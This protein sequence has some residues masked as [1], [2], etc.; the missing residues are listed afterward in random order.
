MSKRS[1]VF[2]SRSLLTAIFNDAL[3]D[4]TP[5]FELISRYVDD[6][7]LAAIGNEYGKGRLCL[8]ARPI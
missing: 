8:L 2:K 1:P 7:M 3:N 6:Q 4:T 5:L